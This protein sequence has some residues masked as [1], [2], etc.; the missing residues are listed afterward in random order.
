MKSRHLI[1]RFIIGWLLLGW[2]AACSGPE[3]TSPLRMQS[4]AHAG[5]RVVLIVLDSLMDE[6][7]QEALRGGK[8]PALSFL[9]KHGRYETG[10]VSSFPTMSVTID[11][12]LLTGT[13]A[14][15]HRIPGL[16]WFDVPHRRYVNY[17]SS[18]VEIMKV[19]P[20]S[21]LTD[22]LFALNN[23]HL[24]KQTPTLHETLA[25]R[26][27]RS[28][29]INALIYRGPSPHTLEVPK[30]VAAAA[31]GSER[32]QT[33]GP[34]LFSLGAFASI[35]PSS[36]R[37]HAHSWQKLGMNDAYSVHE[38]RYLVEQGQL[39]PFTLLY[40]P[41]NDQ[42]IHRFGPAHPRGLAKADKQ[43]QNLL[44]AFGSWEK[45]LEDIIW[46]VIGDSGQAAM[47]ADR[48]EEAIPI[49]QTLDAYR[50]AGLE[51]IR[52]EDQL[53]IC[54]NE[55]MAYI[56]LLDPQLAPDAVAEA[57]RKEPRIDVIAWKDAEGKI[58]VRSGLADR[59]G[60]LVY[61]RAGDT[62]DPY[63]QTWSLEGN[64][65]LLDLTVDYSGGRVSYGDYPDALARLYGAL[66]SQE[67]SFLVATSAERSEFRSEGTYVH[68]GGGAHGSLHKLD[69][70]VPLLTV[71]TE[72]RP[73]HL[74][75]KDLRDW[76]LRLLDAGTPQQSRTDSAHW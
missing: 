61:A 48:S 20:H 16:F 67:G 29:S 55:R 68:K 38:F 65:R 53:V 59:E 41:G 37:Q 19:G 40:L 76:I 54:V 26:G 9:M 70:L 34:P 64:L 12:T 44:N 28:A 8:L 5:K 51:E 27:M 15:Q 24:S 71:G 10:M 30:T 42:D 66:H 21:V 11:S 22:S 75:I 7:L 3:S 60:E 72:E 17:G 52:P 63:G 13:Y 73:A 23:E 74:R 50:V 36:R 43:L 35:D 62:T 39:P 2:M 33:F 4:D 32:Y 47:A 25:A 1:C 18:L 45:A 31:S 58:R 6:T 14:D 56:Y 57:L 69:S 46:I 49:R